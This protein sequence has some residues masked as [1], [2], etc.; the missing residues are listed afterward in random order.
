MQACL[1]TNKHSQ[2]IKRFA[3][4]NIFFN[5]SM[6]CS[7]MLPPWLWEP[8]KVCQPIIS[9]LILWL[10]YASSCFSRTCSHLNTV[11][12]ECARNGLKK[13]RTLIKCFKYLQMFA[14]QIYFIMSVNGVFLSG[15]QHLRLNQIWGCMIVDSVIMVSVCLE[16]MN[17]FE[18][19]YPARISTD[20]SLVIALNVLLFWN[21]CI[22]KKLP[23][24]YFFFRSR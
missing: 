12:P 3:K 10:H 21:L 15:I 7:A 4:I 8:L 13:F 20:H 24:F 5:F 23:F 18:T 9:Y 22:L 11:I 17:P 1:T 14:N 2:R 19:V 6:L 16:K